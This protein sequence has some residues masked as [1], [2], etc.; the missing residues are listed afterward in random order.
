MTTTDKPSD[1]ADKGIDQFVSHRAGYGDDKL[2]RVVDYLRRNPRA[3]LAS[4]EGTLL[5]AEI[6]RLRDDLHTQ[7]PWVEWANREMDALRL[8]NKDAI[9][10]YA[11][12]RAEIDRLRAAIER[13]RALHAPFSMWDSPNHVW[14][15]CCRE[16]WDNNSDYQYPCPTLRALDG[17]A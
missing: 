5:V 2:A 16:C 4:G 11:D 14:V 17:D 8:A 1:P 3:T 6:D 13:V 10:H 15:K 7:E 9:D 12:A